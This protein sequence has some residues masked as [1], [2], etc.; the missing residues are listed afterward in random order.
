MGHARWYQ[1]ILDENLKLR[2]GNDA[3]KEENR[4]LKARV[5]QL[6]KRLGRDVRDAREAPYA[7]NTPSSKR[8]FKKDSPEE[9]RRRQGGAKPGHEGHGRKA[10]AAEEADERRGAEAGGDAL[11]ALTRRSAHAT[12]APLRFT[13]RLRL[14]FGCVFK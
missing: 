1:D 12:S 6:E 10:V 8:N 5:A 13:D 7:E 4:L 9:R 3:V 14:A 2:I 11:G